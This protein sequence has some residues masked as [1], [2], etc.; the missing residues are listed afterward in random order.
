MKPPLM[1]AFLIGFIMYNCS[2]FLN[3][4]EVKSYRTFHV[5]LEELAL[6]I[7]VPAE[8]QKGYGGIKERLVFKKSDVPNLYQLRVSGVE[9]GN[10]G[11]L[12]LGLR[13]NY[14]DWDLSTSFY[15]L[16]CDRDIRPMV[17]DV[18]VVNLA[19]E[20]LSRKDTLI[21]GKKWMI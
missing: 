19:R 12:Y 3:G 21:N 20:V 1:K 4:S 10:L 14:Q 17:S 15:V 7:T 6:E 8:L 16:Q 5:D 2:C 18:D 13:N 11:G 9:W